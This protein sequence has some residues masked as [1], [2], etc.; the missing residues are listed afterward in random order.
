MSGWHGESM[1]H[2]LASKGITTYQYL[3]VRDKQRNE[4]RVRAIRER[5]LYLSQFLSDWFIDKLMVYEVSE[6]NKDE[7]VSLD[8]RN[9]DLR[10]KNSIG[11]RAFIGFGYVI[12][13]LYGIEGVIKDY[14]KGWVVVEIDGDDL[15]VRDFNIRYVERDIPLKAKK[16]RKV[17][18]PTGE[19]RFMLKE[20]TI[21]LERYEALPI[22]WNDK[23][24]IPIVRLW[25]HSK[26]NY[27]DVG[28]YF[29]YE[30]K[31][32]QLYSTPYVKSIGDIAKRKDARKIAMYYIEKASLNDINALDDNVRKQIEAS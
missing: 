25:Y 18:I 9:R 28:Y 7:W 24:L 31:N 23:R 16:P 2:Q 32:K 5:Q 13:S 14:G 29:A 11:K 8:K 3:N 15:K 22:K 19:F 12:D 1:R 30:D 20:D 10:I 6:F 21:K 17:N 4:L 27:W 26:F